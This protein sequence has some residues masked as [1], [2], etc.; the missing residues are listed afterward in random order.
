MKPF[1][2]AR[3]ILLPAVL[4]ALA[5]GLAWK[6]TELAASLPA[7]RV[8]ILA[9]GGASYLVPARAALE[10]AGAD[11]EAF[12][13]T[14]ENDRLVLAEV[15]LFTAQ[16]ADAALTHA[17]ITD[18][19]V[20]DYSWGKE[21]LRQ[22]VT[23]RRMGMALAAIAALLWWLACG[24]RRELRCAGAA[25]RHSYWQEWLPGHA[26]ALLAWGIAALPCL[27]AV[28]LLARWLWQVEIVLPAGLIPAGSLFDRAHYAA[29]LERTFPAGHCS[30]YAA[31]LRQTIVQS[32][33]LGTASGLAFLAW[34]GWGRCMNTHQKK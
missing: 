16:Q 8:E 17:G 27:L 6:Q 31:A 10:Q 13:A 7:D 3:K 18:V 25:L 9:D 14:L 1:H 12:V 32:L 5:I 4:L 33:R 15:T 26:A 29:W 28:A 11:G 21:L 30:A 23:L 19:R 34:L 2:M 22:L 20:L 24:V